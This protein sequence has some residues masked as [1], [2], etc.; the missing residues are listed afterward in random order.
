MEASGHRAL[1][2]LGGNLG[3]ALGE[4]AEYISA[5][6]TLLGE[7]SGINVLKTSALYSSEAWGKEDQ[8][9]FINAVAE[10]RCE[11]STN[12]LLDLL[13]EIEEQLGRVRGEKWGPRL[14]DLDL[15]V[16]DEEVIVGPK[17]I[18]PHPH[19]H[20]RA[21]VLVPLL[22]LHP[23]FVV[24]GKGRADVLLGGLDDASRVKRVNSLCVKSGV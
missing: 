7:T 11:M 1:I 8:P 24:P 17:L 23:E 9:D 2:G 12:A 4:P 19:M 5:A 15:L 10:L 16:F 6:I 13:L 3:G 18:L 21:F 22:E 14:I 20:E